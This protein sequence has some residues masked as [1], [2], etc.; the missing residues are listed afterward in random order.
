MESGDA[1]KNKDVIN[2]AEMSN[3]SDETCTRVD[4]AGRGVSVFVLLY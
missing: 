1:A 4:S 2:T 3:G